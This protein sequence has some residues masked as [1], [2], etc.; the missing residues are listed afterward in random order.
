[1]A[2]DLFDD[3][4]AYL[5]ATASDQEEDDQTDSDIVLECSLEVEKVSRGWFSEEE[6]WFCEVTIRPD[7]C[8]IEA[9][10]GYVWLSDNSYPSLDCDCGFCQKAI[11]P[12]IREFIQCCSDIQEQDATLDLIIKSCIEAPEPV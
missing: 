10:T 9:I 7:N 12:N 4:E 2:E 1:M 8:D 5:E 6:C 3:T 11:S